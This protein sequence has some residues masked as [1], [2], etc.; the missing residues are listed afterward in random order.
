VSGAAKRGCRA[1][2][3]R[4]RTG[5]RLLGLALDKC[6]ELGRR[7][8]LG[9][10]IAPRAVAPETPEAWPPPGTAFDVIYAI[11]YWPGEPKRYRVLN[12][13]EGLR[14]ASYSVQVIPYEA[15]DEIAQ[16]RWT[17][18]VLVLFRAEY[19]PL[20]GVAEAL[21]YAR[22]IGMQLVYDIDDLL[23]DRSVVDRID[24]LNRMGRFERRRFVAAIAGHRRLMLACDRITVSTA[25]L[26]R[27]AEAAGRPAA[28]V[29][30]GLN[31]AQ[32]RLADEIAAPP[33]VANGSVRIGYFSGSRTHQRDFA[34]CEPA[35]LDLIARHA[36]VRLRLVGYLD[37]GAAWRRFE[38]RIERIGFQSP[39]DLLRRIAE[40]D[41]NLAPLELGNP[42]CEAKS[43]LKFF[44]AA[45]VG[46]PTI[47]SAT[48]PFAAAIEDGVSGFLARDDDEWRRAL[49]ALLASPERRQTIGAAA[50]T[51][52][53][54]RHGPVAITARAVA[55][56]G[57]PVR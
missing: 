6:G 8:L 18:R 12:M 15:I 45:L 33:R 7:G 4:T 49:D 38:D 21:A 23:F 25:P 43:E 42:F 40:T 39:S 19:D 56:L 48:E 50:R 37:L 34:A 22:A 9:R 13:A 2:L 24:G 53:L 14:A 17:A 44:E 54:A 57:L 1:L 27:A 35:L 16:R 31:V 36:E 46:V 41:I 32:L 28:V 3:R 5:F 29:P 47:A 10:A 11:G 52:A 51:R 20:V 26:A 30:N 55:A